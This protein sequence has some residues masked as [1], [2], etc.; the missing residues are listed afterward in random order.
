MSWSRSALRVF[1][2][3]AANISLTR[4]KIP[5]NSPRCRIN[6]SSASPVIKIPGRRHLNVKVVDAIGALAARE[7]LKTLSE[8]AKTFSRALPIF[9]LSRVARPEFGRRSRS[10]FEC[11]HMQA[12]LT[13][14]ASTLKYSL[15]SSGE[16]RFNE[17]R[18]L[19]YA[20]AFPEK[21]GTIRDD[22]SASAWFGCQSRQSPACAIGPSQN[23]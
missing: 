8:S 16:T 6:S 15:R 9:Y 20:I 1:N 5:A 7:R 14:C 17:P 23:M 18:A 10:P 12:V 3:R 2:T 19:A 13:P 4:T 21:P 11:V 22:Q